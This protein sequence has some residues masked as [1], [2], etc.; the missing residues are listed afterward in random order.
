MYRYL[1]HLCCQ[2]VFTVV[3]NCVSTGQLT[4]PI[5][6]GHQGPALDAEPQ[7]SPEALCPQRTTTT[8]PGR[9]VSFELQCTLF[10]VV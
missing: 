1:A 7:E 9:C 4:P 5:G 10:F 3:E 8:L 2:T 6:T